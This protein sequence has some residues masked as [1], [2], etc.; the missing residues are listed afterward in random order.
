MKAID[1][2]IEAMLVKMG[3]EGAEIQSVNLETGV[4][5]S[6]VVQADI[7]V[8]TLIPHLAR[9]L[10]DWEPLWDH[11]VGNHPVAQYCSG[12]TLL[13]AG[14]VTLET[15]R[16]EVS[17]SAAHL[18]LVDVDPDWLNEGVNREKLEYVYYRSSNSDKDLILGMV[19]H[20]HNFISHLHSLLRSRLSRALPLIFA[21]T[22]KVAKSSVSQVVTRFF[23]VDH[24]INAQIVV[25]PVPVSVADQIISADWDVSSVSGA[26]KFL[27]HVNRYLLGR[28]MK[29]RIYAVIDSSDA[30]PLTLDAN[31]GCFTSPLLVTEY[32]MVQSHS[33]ALYRKAINN[34]LKQVNLYAQEHSDDLLYM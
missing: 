33:S 34:S 21:V 16:F 32:K 20:G 12:A 2:L 31:L 10:R 29:R 6:L 26:D 19:E 28:V 23:S 5:Q 4:I 15:L 9:Y 24:Q 25:E 30:G 1:K 22:D 3:F 13:K 11:D 27:N 18:R 17:L 7:P 8:R 14:P